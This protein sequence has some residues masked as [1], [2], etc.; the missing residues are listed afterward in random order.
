MVDVH[1]QEPGGKAFKTIF[2]LLTSNL[3]TSLP[4]IITKFDENERTCSVQPSLQRL[5]TGDEEAT[6]LPEQEDVPVAYPG[7]RE[8]YL[9]YKLSAGDEVLCIVSERAL[10]HWL[11]LGGIVDPQSARRF[12]LSDIVVVAG[13]K[14]KVNIQGP[15]EDGIAMR[16][17]TGTV[18]VRVQSDIIVAEVNQMSFEVSTLGVKARPTLPILADVQGYQPILVTPPGIGPGYVSLVNHTHQVTTIGA[19]TG[20]P[21][22]IP[23][24]P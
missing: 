17:A 20:L 21:I 13:M 10:D 16:N 1:E 15:V 12:S 6:L 11:D 23:G 7:S 4:G 18:F 14:S 22:P 3:H 5:Y 8:F 24:P 9:E 2:D 19:P